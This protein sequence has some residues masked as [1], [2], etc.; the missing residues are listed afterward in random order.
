MENNI[1][2]Q[3]MATYYIKL[4]KCGISEDSVNTLSEKYGDL[5]ANASFSMKTDCG[6]AYD[7]SLVETALTILIVYVV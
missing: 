1:V 6:L 3:L 7:G 2:N 5:I 4:L